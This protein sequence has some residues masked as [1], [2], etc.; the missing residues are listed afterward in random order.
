V[1]VSITPLG[2][3]DGD[4]RRAA[5]QVVGYVE[6]KISAARRVAIDPGA[7]VRSYYADSVEGPGWWTGQ[8]STALGLDGE[9]DPDHLQRV[10]LGKHPGTGAQLRTNKSRGRTS[11][12]RR[13]AAPEEPLSL[14]RRRGSPGSAASI[15]DR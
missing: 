8:G 3:V 12:A 14:T 5:H 2:S 10:L 15:L 1:L 11:E 7:G 4:P 6:A 13:S 9:V